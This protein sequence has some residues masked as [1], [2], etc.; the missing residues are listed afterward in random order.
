M[1]RRESLPL[2]MTW[3]AK[4]V[5]VGEIEA[6]IRGSVGTCRGFRAGRLDG[7]EDCLCFGDWLQRVGYTLVLLLLACA[8]SNLYCKYKSLSG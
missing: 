2:C 5:R 7:V 6:R 3:K 1:P 8:C 4:P